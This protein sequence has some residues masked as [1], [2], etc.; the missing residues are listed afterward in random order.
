M[1][2]GRRRPRGDDLAVEPHGVPDDR[3][4]APPACKH[5]P[6]LCDLL[7]RRPNASHC[8]S[9]AATSSSNVSMRRATAPAGRGGGSWVRTSATA[10]GSLSC[11][12]HARAARPPVPAARS[13]RPPTASSCARA[14][15]ASRAPPRARRRRRRRGSAVA[16]R[17]STTH[18]RP[19]RACTARCRS[20]RRRARAARTSSDIRQPHAAR[21]EA[22]LRRSRAK[23][24]LNRTDARRGVKGLLWEAGRYARN[25]K[26]PVAYFPVWMP[27]R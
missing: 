1:L 19:C 16:A 26:R 2:G 22:T 23:R 4:I 3:R 7:R 12:G 20:A 11:R 18:R 21:D 17:C 5:R 6:R 9:H 27:S 15:A 14:R 25:P 10:Y 24:Q 8:T 13:C